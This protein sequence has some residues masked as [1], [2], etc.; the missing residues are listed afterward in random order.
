M[1]DSAIVVVVCALVT[2]D[3]PTSEGRALLGGPRGL[4]GGPNGCM[5]RFER[6]PSHPGGAMQRAAGVGHHSPR[7]SGASREGGTREEEPSCCDWAGGANMPVG[8]SGAD[9]GG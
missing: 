5:Q 1:L 7:G 4:L 2:H 6:R 9:T 8:G 3:R